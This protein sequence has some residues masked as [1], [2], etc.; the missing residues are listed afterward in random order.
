MEFIET[1]VFCKAAKALFGDEGLRQLQSMLL[2][3]PT[4]G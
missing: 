3:S 4:M 1:S 2:L